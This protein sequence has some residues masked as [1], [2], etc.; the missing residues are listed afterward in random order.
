V[1]VLGADQ[2]ALCRQLAGRGDK[3]AGVDYTLSPGGLPL[4]AAR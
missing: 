3:F 2:Q 4:L 1:N